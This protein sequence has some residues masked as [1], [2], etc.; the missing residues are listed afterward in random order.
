MLDDRA[1]ASV[2]DIELP[3]G[4]MGSRKTGSELSVSAF[5][6]KFAQHDSLRAS[7]DFLERFAKLGLAKYEYLKE[8]YGH[9]QTI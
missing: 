2:F 9:L 1:R 7:Y 8:F 3:A 4:S 5:G 6:V